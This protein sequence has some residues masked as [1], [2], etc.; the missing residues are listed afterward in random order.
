V[1]KYVLAPND[2]DNCRIFLGQRQKPWGTS[3]T[4]FLYALG[5]QAISGLFFFFLFDLK[6]EFNTLSSNSSSTNGSDLVHKV[7]IIFPSLF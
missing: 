3:A 7:K 2:V 4:I 1:Y 6:C 5:K